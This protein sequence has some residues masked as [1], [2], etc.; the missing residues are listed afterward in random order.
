[1]RSLQRFSE[2]DREILE[3]EPWL[4]AF[5]QDP[6]TD[7]RAAEGRYIDAMAA[8]LIEHRGQVLH[9]RMVTSEGYETTALQ[10]ST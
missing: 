10:V 2:S 9:K 1:M 6:D 3:R 7:L 5:I 4:E 8:C